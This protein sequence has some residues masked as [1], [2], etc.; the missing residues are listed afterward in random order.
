VG[1]W[2]LTD[3]G[4]ERIQRMIE[5]RESFSSADWERWDYAYIIEFT[6]DGTVRTWE[7]SQ[8]STTWAWSIDNG[9]LIISGNSETYH[10][11]YS[12]SESTVEFRNCD[13]EYADLFLT[14]ETYFEE[15]MGRGEVRDPVP[16]PRSTPTPSD[17]DNFIGIWY[18]DPDYMMVDYGCPGSLDYFRFRDDGS[19]ESWVSDCDVNFHATGTWWLE[20]GIMHTRTLADERYDMVPH[21]EDCSYEIT[22]TAI[23]LDCDGPYRFP[24]RRE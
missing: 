6:T 2:H 1:R 11:R 15:K 17:E 4:E 21:S 9:L 19:M 20:Q 24:L 13:W 22:P 16:S 10:C 18:I 14:R 12:A 8:P 5:D 7:N 23:W 3:A